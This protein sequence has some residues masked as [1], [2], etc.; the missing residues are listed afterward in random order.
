M[1]QRLRKRGRLLL[2][3]AHGLR[4]RRLLAHVK[5]ARERSRQRVPGQIAELG[6]ERAALEA[7]LQVVQAPACDTSAPSLP[8]L[9]RVVCTSE[10]G[11]PL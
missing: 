3:R 7:L 6:D 11:R 5:A 9:D 4:V 10:G 1:R 2:R 8:E